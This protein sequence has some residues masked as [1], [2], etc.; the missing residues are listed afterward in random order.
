MAMRGRGRAGFRGGRAGGAGALGGR[1]PLKDDNGQ[2]IDI[3]TAGPAPLFPVSATRLRRHAALEARRMH[4]H[5]RDNAA[6]GGNG[7]KGCPPE[8]KVKGA[9]PQEVRLPDPPTD[10]LMNKEQYEL[11]E[12]FRRARRSSAFGVEAP[13]CKRGSEEAD[14]E[15]YASQ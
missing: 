13:A 14:V 10:T 6:P 2:V 15:R 7:R 3:N 5:G 11:H 12:Q 4:A 9:P 8:L 1:M